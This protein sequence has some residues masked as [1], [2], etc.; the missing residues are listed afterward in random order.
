MFPEDEVASAGTT[1]KDAGKC[2][3]EDILQV[4]KEE[5]ADTSRHIVKKL[6]PEMVQNA[7]R[8]VVLCE[9][10]ECPDFLLD[11]KKIEFWPLEDP[12]FAGI[13]GKRETVRILKKA[14]EERFGHNHHYPS[15]EF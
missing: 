6:T 1:A 11:S 15:T 5:G 7:D 4:L 3:P 13:D 10:S 9:K 12:E 2:P 14:I 8:V